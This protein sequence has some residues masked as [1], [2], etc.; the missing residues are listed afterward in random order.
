MADRVRKRLG[1]ATRYI[2]LEFL[3]LPLFC[4]WDK[5]FKPSLSPPIFKTGRILLVGLLGGFEMT[6]N[7]VPGDQWV[8]VRT[9]GD[10]D[11]LNLDFLPLIL[12][13]AADVRTCGRAGRG[14]LPDS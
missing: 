13:L 8:T 11:D 5:R 10:A 9:D 3:I 12:R 14:R 2:R 7:Q 1:F 6:S 4:L